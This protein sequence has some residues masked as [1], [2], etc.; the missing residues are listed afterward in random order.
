MPGVTDQKVLTLRQLEA[1]FPALK[2]SVRNLSSQSKQNKIVDLRRVGRGLA[3]VCA[4]IIMRRSFY[5]GFWIEHLIL[6]RSSRQ[7]WDH[8]LA[9]HMEAIG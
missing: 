4:I 2:R 1:T 7:R 8:S 6:K 9:I 3:K 5:F